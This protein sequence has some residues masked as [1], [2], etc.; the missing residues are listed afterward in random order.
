MNKQIQT[1]RE[2]FQRLESLNR[3]SQ[4]TRER[5]AVIIQRLDMTKRL[6]EV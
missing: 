2:L 3:N 5:N 4:T 1:A 6:L